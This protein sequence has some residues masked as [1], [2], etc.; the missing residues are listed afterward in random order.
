MLYLKCTNI[1]KF[2]RTIAV[3]SKLFPYRDEIWR[4]GVISVHIGV[5]E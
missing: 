1:M 5:L 3:E 4:G 2:S